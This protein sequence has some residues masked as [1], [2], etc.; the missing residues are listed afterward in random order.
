[1]LLGEVANVPCD[2]IPDEP[3]RITWIISPDRP[4]AILETRGVLVVG[5]SALEALDRL[6]VLEATAEAASTARSIGD[7]VTM[8]DAAVGQLTELLAA[9]RI[10]PRQ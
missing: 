3:G 7:P 9:R 4:A 8:S 1:M 2:Q 6:E 5:R 10:S